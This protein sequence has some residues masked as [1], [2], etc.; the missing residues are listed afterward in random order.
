MCSSPAT[1]PLPPVPHPP[2]AT[3]PQREVIRETQGAF[4]LGMSGKI[5]EEDER[6]A[7]GRWKE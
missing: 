2:L 1:L 4:V 5:K 6:E 7:G 3:L